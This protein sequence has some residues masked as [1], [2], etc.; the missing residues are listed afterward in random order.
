MDQNAPVESTAAREYATTPGGK[1]RTS[2][3]PQRVTADGELVPDQH[4]G[5]TIDGRDILV[6]EVSSQEVNENKSS[7]NKPLVRVRIPDGINPK[8]FR[9]VIA[10]VFQAY[11]LGDDISVDRVAARTGVA[12][13]SVG[14]IFATS[15]FKQAM[16]IRGVVISGAPIGI[17]ADQGHALEILTDISDRRTFNQK[18]KAA[19]ITNA[20]YRAWMK[21]PAFAQIVRRTAED[22]MHANEQGMIQLASKA[23]D[24]DMRAIAFMWEVNNKHN[25]QRQNQQ[26]VNVIVSSI[27]EVVYRNV[28]DPDILGNIS[29][30]LKVLGEASGMVSETREIEGGPGN[31]IYL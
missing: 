22:V 7:W 10:N 14:Q 8:T 9:D 29:R 15:Q 28:K 18:L 24:G 13:T 4:F 25:P 12:E 21:N 20:K 30:E 6:P 5:E 17:S 23:A 11:V 3:S 16:E 19:G 26:D 2:Q 1:V 31:G 27:L